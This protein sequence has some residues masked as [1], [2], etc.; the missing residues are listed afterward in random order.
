MCKAF[1]LEECSSYERMRLQARK[2]VTKLH[3]K[4]C[5]LVVRS[6]SY[7][8]ASTNTFGAAIRVDFF[9]FG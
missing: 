7:A 6:L 9:I 1:A 4:M 8:R 5:A 3:I 2:L